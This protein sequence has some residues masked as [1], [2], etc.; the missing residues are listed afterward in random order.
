[1][2]HRRSRVNRKRFLLPCLALLGVVA[3]VGPASAKQAPA[4]PTPAKPAGPILVDVTQKAGISFTH[5]FGDQEMSSILEATG[6]GCAFLD[7]DQD[8]DLDIYVVN[9]AHLPGINDPLPQTGTDE[10]DAKDRAP[11]KELVNRLFRSNGDGTFTDVTAEA[12]VGDTGYGIGVV[13]GDY[14]NDGDPDLFLANYG[15]NV[16]LRNDGAGAGGKVTF[17]DVTEKA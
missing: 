4:K 9:G 3:A 14:D 6:P 12:G 10:T 13:V 16:L 2:N 11:A 5:S 15:P 17:S 7:Y 8:G 1:M